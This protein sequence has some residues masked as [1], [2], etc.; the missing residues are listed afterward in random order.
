MVHYLQLP[1]EIGNILKQFVGK[2]RAAGVTSYY[3]SLQTTTEYPPK[4]NPN[5][6]AIFRKTSHKNASE[7]FHE[8]T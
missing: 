4:Y 2:D 8:I 6:Q 5:M 3:E 7:N 1:E